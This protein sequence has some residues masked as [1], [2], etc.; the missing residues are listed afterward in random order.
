M[1]GQ[2]YVTDSYDRCPL[3]NWRFEGVLKPKLIYCRG[4]IYYLLGEGSWGLGPREKCEKHFR[5]L[6]IKQWLS[7]RP[8][9]LDVQLECFHQ[10]CQGRAYQEGNE[11]DRAFEIKWNNLLQEML[12]DDY[13]GTI[14][15]EGREYKID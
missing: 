7:N 10:R 2:L 3:T 13:L 14:T 11:F 1:K 8:Y 4:G 9:N 12:W 15:L 6:A 5:K